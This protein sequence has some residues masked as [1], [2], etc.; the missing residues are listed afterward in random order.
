[1]KLHQG[2]LPFFYPLSKPIISPL[3]MLSSGV[4]G[5]ILSKVDGTLIVTV[6]SKLLLPHKIA[7]LDDF[8]VSFN[9]CHILTFRGR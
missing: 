2:K 5:D 9:Y 4:V 8:F 7:H 6:E 3:D 1:M